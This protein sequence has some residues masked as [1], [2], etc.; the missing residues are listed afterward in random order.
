METIDDLTIAEWKKRAEQ[1]EKLVEDYKEKVE[2]FESDL[3]DSENEVTSLEEDLAVAED[4]YHRDIGRLD[5]RL[6]SVETFLLYLKNEIDAKRQDIQDPLLK[7]NF[8]RL[9]EGW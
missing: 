4:D 1:A 5:E 8:T 3:L 6:E 2:K 9:I 7:D